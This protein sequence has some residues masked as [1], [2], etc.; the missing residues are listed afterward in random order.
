MADG[1]K[2]SMKP[3]FLIYN[4]M[5]LQPTETK[6][7]LTMDNLHDLIMEVCSR[8]LKG[9]DSISWQK[10]P[11]SNRVR[12]Y[13]WLTNGDY[14]NDSSTE[15]TML[16]QKLN[17]LS[18]EIEQFIKK[19]GWRPSDEDINGTDKVSVKHDIVYA[20]NNIQ[21]KLVGIQLSPQAFIKVIFDSNGTGYKEEFG[22]NSPRT[23]L[24]FGYIYEKDV[25]PTNPFDRRKND[26]DKLRGKVIG[27]IVIKTLA[28]VFESN[29]K[30]IAKW[31]GSFK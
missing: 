31:S 25:T 23:R 20:K 28:H 2:T 3:E 4:L 19:F 29:E 11:K 21:R 22:L 24:Q 30:P 27:A 15:K 7:Q 9:I 14:F 13:L 6:F 1:K 5:G 12:W 17:R 8:E 10:D 16:G 18:P 26:E